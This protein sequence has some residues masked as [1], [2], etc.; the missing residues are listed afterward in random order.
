MN[1]LRR[2]LGVATTPIDCPAVWEENSMGHADPRPWAAARAADAASAVVA[3][4]E[5]VL[6]GKRAQVEIALATLIAGGHLL[7][8]DVP[9]LGKTMLARALAT[10]IGLDFKRIQFTS[11]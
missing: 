2:P 11:D 8:E 9:G 10:S 1:S 6:V 5:K 3:N 4:V 7:L